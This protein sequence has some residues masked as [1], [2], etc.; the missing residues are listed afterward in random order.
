MATALDECDNV[1]QDV[2]SLLAT[3]DQ[4]RADLAYVCT[5]V[6]APESSSSRRSPS[7]NR[8]KKPRLLSF[9]ADTGMK[10]T[11]SG[12]KSTFSKTKYKRW[13]LEGRISPSGNLLPEVKCTIS[14]AEN[15]KLR[16]HAEEHAR[17]IEEMTS[18]IQERPGCR[19]I[20][21]KSIQIA[22]QASLRTATIH[23][24][25]E[26][27]SELRQINS[28]RARPSVPWT[29]HV[30]TFIPSRLG[31]AVLYDWGCGV[32]SFQC[33]VHSVQACVD[34]GD[35]RPIHGLSKLLK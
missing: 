22:A 1:A 33:R 23:S 11:S 10:F 7:L 27:S 9:P 13:R 19:W 2:H 12:A 5:I 6:D 15:D 21:V 18:I 3:D 34:I 14:L 31:S 17:Y 32:E 16:A 8:E 25:D 35:C 28:I 24:A 26:K 20:S 30:G 4:L 29:S